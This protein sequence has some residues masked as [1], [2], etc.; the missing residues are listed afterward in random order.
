MDWPWTLW[1]IAVNCIEIGL[2]LY[3]LMHQLSYKK[4]KLKA[5]FLAYIGIVALVTT[6]NF[7]GIPSLPTI[8]IV[9][10]A[11]LLYTIF[12]FEGTI[13]KRLLWGCTHTVI[14]QVGN[15]LTY[16]IFNMFGNV[17]LQE[18]LSPTETRFEMMVC[19]VLL[20]ALIYFILAHIR[21]KKNIFL[22]LPMRIAMIAIFITGIIAIQKI[23]DI[24]HIDLNSTSD[25]AVIHGNFIFVSAVIIGTFL[26][27]LFMFEYIGSLAQKNVE[28]QAELQQKKW[29]NAH[30]QNVKDTYQ[31]LRSWKHDFQNHLEVMNTY[32]KGNKHEELEKYLSQISGEIEPLMHLYYTGNT[33]ADAVLSNKLFIA[34]AKGIQVNASLVLPE[35]LTISDVQLCS[36]LSNLLDNAIEAQNGVTDPF[37]NVTIRPERGML[38]IKI[39][40]STTGDYVFKKNQLISSKKAK[41]HGIGLNQVKKI[42]EKARGIIDIQPQTKL[43]IVK[44]LMPLEIES[45]IVA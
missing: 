11:D 37:I 31:A 12:L 18:S 36:V 13:P 45:E 34:H 40:N 35:K 39:E 41:D 38:Y 10:A 33:V 32:L 1:E 23:V 29:E 42:V 20:I 7:T 24:F 17:N 2:F 44:I 14:A 9:L 30:F 26:G 21:T 4:E 19:Y 5:I 3:L 27:M 15:V 8:L 25:M 22:N 6:L 16:N 28:T 43:F